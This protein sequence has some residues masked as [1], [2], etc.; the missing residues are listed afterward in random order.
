VVNKY[1]KTGVV[2]KPEN[3]NSQVINNRKTP[4]IRGGYP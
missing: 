2:S 1:R 4:W 3:G